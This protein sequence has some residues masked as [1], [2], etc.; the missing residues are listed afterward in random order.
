MPTWGFFKGK[1]IDRKT[2]GIYTK[3]AAIWSDIDVVLQNEDANAA[4]IIVYA[5]F[6]SGHSWVKPRDATNKALQHELGHFNITEIYA[7]KLRRQ[8][9]E[10]I[11]TKR[12]LFK[13][14]TQLY[15]D[16]LTK[17]EKA[18]TEY[19]VETMHSTNEAYQKQWEEMIKIQL[20][21][22]EAFENI[23]L[24]VRVKG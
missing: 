7:R 23:Y 16:H 20:K 8:C 10:T 2:Y 21:E 18:Q 12:N 17:L 4:T 3:G 13:E 14:L 6:D 15:N 1:E 5:Y 24:T 22:T 11:F 19:Y 9:N